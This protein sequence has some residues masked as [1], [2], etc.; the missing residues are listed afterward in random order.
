M[1][2]RLSYEKFCGQMNPIHL[3]LIHGR[4]VVLDKV[5]NKSKIVSSHQLDIFGRD[6]WILLRPDGFVVAKGS[7][8]DISKAYNVV[9]NLLNG[10]Y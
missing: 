8:L 2:D 7:N 10:D 6:V 4:G 9:Q 5:T 3:N 1:K